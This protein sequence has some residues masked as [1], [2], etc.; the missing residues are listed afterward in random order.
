[1]RHDVRVPAVQAIDEDECWRLL[2]LAPLGRI[3]L[4]S[5][6]LPAIVPVHFTLWRGDVVFASLPDVK[7]RSAERGDVLVLEIDHFDAATEEGWSVSTIGPARL[8]RDAG[9]IAA[10]HD[11]R[12]TPW[13]GMRLPMVASWVVARTTSAESDRDVQTRS[14]SSLG[15]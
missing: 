11:L 5:G 13:A 6:A 15:S 3:G 7:I 2:Q 8:V 14:C 1:M 10:L 4:T 12:F 9:E